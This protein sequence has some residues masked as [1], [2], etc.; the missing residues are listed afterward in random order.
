MSVLCVE[1]VL[2]VNLLIV[3]SVLGLFHGEFVC[4]YIRR[5]ENALLSSFKHE[6]DILIFVGATVLYNKVL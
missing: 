3:L 2:C 6:L 4:G 1:N 5:R